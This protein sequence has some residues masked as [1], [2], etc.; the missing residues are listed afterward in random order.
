MARTRLLAALV[1]LGSSCGEPVSPIA[2]NPAAPVAAR[3]TARARLEREPKEFRAVPSAAAGEL[4][5]SRTLYGDAAPLPL[6]VHDGWL[7]LRAVSDGA[8]ARLAVEHFDL[9]LDDLVFS[10]SQVPPHGLTFTRARFVLEQGVALPVQWYGD[11]AV[12][13]ARGELPLEFQAWVVLADESL[14]P[15]PFVSFSTPVEIVAAADDAGG[16]RLA[17]DLARQG[18][19][20]D[21]GG[22]LQLGELELGVEAAEAALP[23]HFQERTT[24]P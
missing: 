19:F 11:G 16:L 1:L 14:S 10:A 17:V 20:W 24:V 6:G 12:G 18:A 8:G 15:L 4:L 9:A 21:W 23:E 3:A 7:E 2:V 22:L 13:V 5:A